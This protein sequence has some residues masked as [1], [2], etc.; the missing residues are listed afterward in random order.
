MVALSPRSLIGQAHGLIDPRGR[1][2]NTARVP[3]L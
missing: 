1:G 3:G 2:H